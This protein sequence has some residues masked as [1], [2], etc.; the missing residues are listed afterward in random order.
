M[1]TPEVMVAKKPIFSF[2]LGLLDMD[3]SNST[4]K[5]SS[6]VEVLQTLIYNTIGPPCL[7]DVGLVSFLDPI[8]LYIHI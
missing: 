7:T 4:T 8:I 3:L 6:R 1:E 5:T 2:F